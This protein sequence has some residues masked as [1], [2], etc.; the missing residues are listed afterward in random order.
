MRSTS[1]A[2]ASPAEDVLNET[3]GFQ[4]IGGTQRD[5]LY[6]DDRPWPSAIELGDKS[7]DRADI[8]GR[9]IDEHR[10]EALIGRDADGVRA[11]RTVHFLNV[12]I[13][14]HVHDINS[15][16]AR[17]LQD[18]EC[19]TADRI[20]LSADQGVDQIADDL[21][22][23][24]TGGDDET[25]AGGVGLD[26]YAVHGRSG[27]AERL[28]AFAHQL[29]EA[30]SQQLGPR[31]LQWKDVQADGRIHRHRF[32]LRHELPDCGHVLD[33]RRHQQT[34]G[35]GISHHQRLLAALDL[36]GHIGVTPLHDVVDCLGDPLD[37]GGGQRQ[38]VQQADL[39][40]VRS[41]QISDETLDH[42]VRFLTGGDDQT[43]G[44]GIVDDRCLLEVSRLRLD[45]AK[46]LESRI[47]QF[48]D[49]GSQTRR[50]CI[51]Q[52]DSPNL[53]ELRGDLGIERLKQA[54]QD[55]E[56]AGAGGDDERVG[57]L[58][59]LGDDTILVTNN[60]SLDL[61]IE[62][63]HHGRGQPRRGG[64]FDGINAYGCPRRGGFDVEHGHQL[65]DHFKVHGRADENQGVELR[66]RA[67]HQVSHG[68]EDV[69]LEH[70]TAVFFKT[71]HA[72]APDLPLQRRGLRQIADA[73][74]ENRLEGFS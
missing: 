71:G 58:V 6:L 52:F 2:D 13:L 63:A 61:L 48:T 64:V 46:P 4:G 1:S 5:V 68:D 29:F 49:D 54:L 55:D 66:F 59:S 30:G 38:H 34:V 28:L 17:E 42:L 3:N 39:R 70:S 32:E 15:A 60:V 57:A 25:V 69:R 62:Q 16:A 41:V 33:V 67:D 8:C 14:E 73:F 35:A 7:S 18:L 56:A 9:R 74:N 10:V 65:G 44:A 47:H 50:R 72:Q 20:R 43:V 53:A 22:V 11:A 40:Q 26:R 31:A 27:F 45:L 36:G 23:L 51:L 19:R 37:V 21:K 24:L 12:H